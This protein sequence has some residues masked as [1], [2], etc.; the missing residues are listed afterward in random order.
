MTD[1]KS[2][3]CD[4]NHG[5][6]DRKDKPGARSGMRCGVASFHSGKGYP[7]DCDETSGNRK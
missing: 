1:R 7:E 2:Y 6:A 3:R 4:G 5:M